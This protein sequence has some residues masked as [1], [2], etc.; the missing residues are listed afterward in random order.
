MMAKDLSILEPARYG[1]SLL[2]RL[3]DREAD[4]EFLHGLRENDAA[5]FFP[6]Y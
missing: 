3:H 6:P 2:I 4:Q 5:G 1:L